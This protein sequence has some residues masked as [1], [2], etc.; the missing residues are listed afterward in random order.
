VKEKISLWLKKLRL[1]SGEEWLFAFHS[2]AKPWR[3]AVTLLGLIFV[4]SFFALVF[5]GNRS[6]MIEV[7]AKGGVLSEG[8]TGSPR[9]IN[10]LLTAS[11]ADRDLTILIYSGLLRLAP[12][13]GYEPD[14][15]ENYE[16]SADGLTYTFYLKP[17]L[18]W[19]DG[20][21]LTADDVVFTI[22]LAQ[23]QAIKSPKR[24]NWNGVKVAKLDD[25]TVQ[26]SLKR[27]FNFFLENATLGI[28]PAHLWQEVTPE[29]FP[30]VG[31]NTEPIGSGPYEIES[32]TKDKNGIPKSYRL[33]PFKNFALG[34]PKIDLILRFYN[35][36]GELLEALNNG[37]IRA[38]SAITT[39]TATKL[40][41][42]GR[43]ILRSPLP[44]IFAVFFNQS[45]NQILLDPAIREALDLATDRTGLVEEVLAGYG[46]PLK[47]ALPPS[48]TSAE[49]AMAPTT[50]NL[51]AAQERLTKAGWI[52]NDH[53]QLEKAG[54]KGAPATKA[55][56]TLATAN[57]EE[58]KLSAQKLAANWSKLGIEIKLE[59]FEPSDLTQ[60]VIRPRSYDVLLFGQIIGRHYDLFSFWHSSQRLDPGLNIALYA[61]SKVDDLLE[62]IRESATIK[63]LSE[64]YSALAQEIT[65]DR[66]AVFLYQP[67]FLYVVPDDLKGVSLP[68]IANPSNRFAQAH[69]WYFRVD[70][71]WKIFAKI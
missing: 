26:F 38:A 55:A 52:I 71:I 32:V 50:F 23:D 4:V 60:D 31:L 68:V 39:A 17:D 51:A 61:N 5:K 3:L 33:K 35:S 8:I 2:L 11:D 63:D 47:N 57:I 65:A 27:P 36:D 58:L 24:G 1:P 49:K 62:E 53:G 19:S 25:R 66:P 54:V 64:K 56:F 46:T 15:A 20:Q 16:L 13:Q 7:P 14:L 45:R 28:L 9:F 48:I 18:T 22:K 10:P 37:E 29:Q 67:D 42:A 59:F 69:R 43:R 21:P 34:A 40:E 30:L 70:R 41:T 6:L 44:R 12:G